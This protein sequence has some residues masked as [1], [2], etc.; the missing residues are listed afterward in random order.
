MPLLEVCCFD[1]RSAIVASEAGA[2]RVELCRDRGSGGLTPPLQD[3]QQAI[4]QVSCPVFVMVRPR[5]GGFVYSDSEFAEM[6]SCIADLTPHAAG[7]VFGC[8]TADSRVNIEQTSELVRLANGLPCTFHRA[9]D[10]TE[11][12]HRALEE[13]IATGCLAILTS[14][15]CS[16]AVQGAHTL[17]ALV[18]QARDRVQVMPGGGVRSANLRD[19]QRRTNARWFHSSCILAESVLPCKAEIKEMREILSP[20]LPLPNQ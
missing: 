7:F 12:P 13:V 16:S 19:L 1:V 4:S 10:E 18:E 3:V 14:G 9:F 17:T 5:G 11:D 20:T 2:D 15:A 8:L 6:K